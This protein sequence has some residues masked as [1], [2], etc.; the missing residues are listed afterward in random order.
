MKNTQFLLCCLVSVVLIAACSGNKTPEE[1]IT[2]TWEIT[3]AE[4]SF[5]DMNLGTIYIFDGKNELIMSKGAFE[6]KAEYKI[7]ADTL[8]YSVGSVSISVLYKIDDNKLN[9]EIIDGDQKFELT[10][11]KE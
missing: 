5:A 3:K 9:L 7:I 11:K 2:G 8:Q 10:R 1:M 6:N 4:G